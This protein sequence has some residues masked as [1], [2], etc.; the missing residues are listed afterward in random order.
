MT[1]ITKSMSEYKRK[2]V[3]KLTNEGLPTHIIAERL[4]LHTSNVNYYQKKLGVW[5][6]KKR[7]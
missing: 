5:K 1:G 4:G 7:K 3:I 6:G 2:Q